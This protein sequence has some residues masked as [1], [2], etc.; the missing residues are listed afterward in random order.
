M[1]EINLDGF[2]RRPV[3]KLI[4]C[5]NLLINIVSGVTF[6]NVTAD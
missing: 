1:R 2:C 6:C 3:K 5:K 4:C